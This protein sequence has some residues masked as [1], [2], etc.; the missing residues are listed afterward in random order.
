MQFFKSWPNG[1]RMADLARSTIA[2]WNRRPFVQLKKKLWKTFV[3]KQKCK[4]IHQLYPI[5]FNKDWSSKHSELELEGYYN[6]WL[7]LTDPGSYG[8]LL[9]KWGKLGWRKYFLVILLS[10]SLRSPTTVSV[11][12]HSLLQHTITGDEN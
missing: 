8:W 12:H 7:T 9:G 5:Y 3:Q 1:I 2:W 11:S 4:L 10:L 6:L